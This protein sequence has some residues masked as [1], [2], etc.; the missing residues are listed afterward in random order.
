VIPAFFQAADI[1][2]IIYV[3]L[4]CV[5]TGWRREKEKERGKGKKKMY[6]KSEITEFWKKKFTIVVVVGFFDFTGCGFSLAEALGRNRKRK[7]LK[8]LP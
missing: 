5:K 8:K 7:R 1:V 3:W 2:I 6:G 4:G